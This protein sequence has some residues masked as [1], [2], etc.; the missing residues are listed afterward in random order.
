MK[1]CDALKVDTDWSMID[2]IY[3]G[4]DEKSDNAVGRMVAKVLW[5]KMERNVRGLVV[6][7]FLAKENWKECQVYCNGCATHLPGFVL[8]MKT[9]MAKRVEDLTDEG[10][11]GED[12][13]HGV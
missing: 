8:D 9:G 2:Q 4:M 3:D 11:D 10:E 6:Q 13:G 1:I 12:G 7:E 5:D